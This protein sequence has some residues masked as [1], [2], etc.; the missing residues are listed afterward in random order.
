M[1]AF[2]SESNGARNKL[3]RIFVSET[4]CFNVTCN[5]IILQ[6]RSVPM[7]AYF[8]VNTRRRPI[9]DAPTG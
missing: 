9:R 1:G 3:F 2:S 7:R 4:V 8:N 5:F 6:N